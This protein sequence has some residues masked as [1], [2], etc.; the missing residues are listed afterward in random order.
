MTTV[1]LP[2]YLILLANA[3]LIAAATFAVLRFGR[4]LRAAS[5]LSAKDSRSGASGDSPAAADS[6]QVQVLATLAT[7]SRAVN[8]LQQREP[9]VAQGQVIDL[10]LEHAVRLAK[11]GASIEEL[12]R[13]CGLNAGEAELLCRLHSPRRNKASVARSA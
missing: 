1:S 11:R 10:S 13:D 8:E 7:L 5:D 6:H 3:A 12:T 9:P 4:L 2:F